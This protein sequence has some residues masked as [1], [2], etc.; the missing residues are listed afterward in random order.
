MLPVVGSPVTTLVRTLPRL[1]DWKYWLPPTV[2]PA[3]IQYAVAPAAALQLNVTVLP[4]KVEFGA[5]DVI[6]AGPALKAL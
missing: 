5:G 6:T 3:S 1:P 2:L 4:L